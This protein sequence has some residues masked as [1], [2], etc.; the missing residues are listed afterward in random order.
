MLV[1]GQVVLGLC[2]LELCLR[3][4]NPLPFR[5]HGD[6]LV[7]PVRQSYRFTNTGTHKLDPVTVHTKN[8]LGFRGPEPPRDWP[9]RLTVLTIGG[10]TTECLFLSDGKTWTDELARRITAVRRDAWVNNAGLDGQSTFGHVVLLREYVAQ[11]HPTLGLFLIGANDVGLGDPTGFDAALAPGTGRVH[12]A[13]AW[14]A[15]HS[16]VASATLNVIR[17]WRT[18][19]AGFGHRELDLRAV[20]RGWVEP[21]EMERILQDHRVRYIAGYRTR[22]RQLVALSHGAGIEPVLITQPALYG[23]AIDPTTGV[24]LIRVDVS[25]WAHGRLAWR[26]LEMYND[27]T[28]EVGRETGTAVIDLASQM[29]K[30]SR[31]YY[32]FL[33]FTNEGAVRVGDIV[34]AGI[35][36]RLSAISPRADSGRSSPPADRPA[37]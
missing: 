19:R 10:S 22:V 14:S 15:D 32:D 34:F 24:D 30:D 36:Q 27:V 1:G 35:E 20:P 13:V 31:Y 16:E 7:L 11:M 2:V 18:H 33:H 4:Y 5:I 17:A 37:P 9:D 25:G 23:E 12:R 28:R 6:R 21:E 29:P 8:S 3:L 26:L